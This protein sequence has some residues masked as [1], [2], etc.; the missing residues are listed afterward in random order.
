[1]LRNCGMTP[2]ARADS[3]NAVPTWMGA[4]TSFPP[5][6]AAELRSRIEA[7][8]V[9]TSARVPSKREPGE[10]MAGA[11][12]SRPRIGTPASNAARLRCSASAS[13]R[14]SLMKL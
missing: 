4:L 1:M 14:R 5:A 6:P 8:C 13:K 7:R 11:P 2:R 3:A 9:R 10:W 12:A